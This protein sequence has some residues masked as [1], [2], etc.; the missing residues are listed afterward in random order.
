MC[1]CTSEVPDTYEQHS[2]LTMWYRSKL[3]KFIFALGCTMEP[4]PHCW[5][6]CTGLVGRMTALTTIPFIDLTLPHWSGGSY[7]LW[8]R[9]RVQWIS[10][11]VGWSPSFKTNWL[12]LVAM[13]FPLVPL[14][15]EQGLSKILTWPMGV[16]GAM[17]S[18]CLT[19]QK[20]C[21]HCPFVSNLCLLCSA[22]YH[23]VLCEGYSWLS[24]NTS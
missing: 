15:L 20:V 7:G 21:Q 16:G 22:R 18:M 2:Q 4:A 17:N 13:A 3:T 10:L 14:S 1:N 6:H 9:L 5:I 12:C 24:T 8:T 23:N 11:G 19:S